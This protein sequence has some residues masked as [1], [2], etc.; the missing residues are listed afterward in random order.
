M[1]FI[2]AKKYTK[3]KNKHIKCK[4]YVKIYKKNYIFN[5]KKNLHFVIFHFQNI[6][7]DMM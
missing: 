4:K 2:K 6:S 5:Y 3:F 1:N 7:Y